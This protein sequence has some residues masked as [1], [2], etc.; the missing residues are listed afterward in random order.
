VISGRT[1][2]RCSLLCVESSN[3]DSSLQQGG[4]NSNLGTGNDQSR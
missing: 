2:R 4:S 3:R 1:F